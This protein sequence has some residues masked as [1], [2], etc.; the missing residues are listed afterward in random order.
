MADD[1][2]ALK[3][4]DSLGW[5]YRPAPHRTSMQVVMNFEGMNEL[6]DAVCPGKILPF[7]R[8]LLKLVRELELSFGIFGPPGLLQYLGQEIV[9]G[10]IVLVHFEGVP[11][12]A[13]GIG[14]VARF[15]VDLAQDDVGP[16][17]KGIQPDR[18]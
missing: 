14:Q 10:V 18:L 3:A 5:A 13:L 17:E 9:A 2:V 15:Q 16:A 6:S 8:A 4:L 1:L 7:G 11:Q 12:H